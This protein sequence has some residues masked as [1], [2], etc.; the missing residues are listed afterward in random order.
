MGKRSTSESVKKVENQREECI[1]SKISMRTATKT[2]KYQG[3]RRENGAGSF[4]QKNGKW[5]LKVKHKGGIKYFSGK[6]PTECNQKRREWE[7][8]GG[9]I[10][11]TTAT[12]EQYAWYW[13]HTYKLPTMKQSSYDRLEETARNQII[14]A[15][16]NVKLKKLKADQIQNMEE[17][18]LWAIDVFLFLFRLFT[19]H[20]VFIL[21]TIRYMKVA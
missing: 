16:G 4:Y 1:I 7:R 19:N 10:D 6:T 18:L 13:M 9:N 15:Q 8:M 20:C 14:P 17:C 21:K 12:V 5:M 2:L 3:G 11:T